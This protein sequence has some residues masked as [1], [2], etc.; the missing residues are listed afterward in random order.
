[1]FPIL[2]INSI[3]K[4]GK[5][6]GSRD[7]CIGD[8]GGPLIC[9]NSAKEPVLYG[10]TSWGIGCATDGYPG[11]YA[12]VSAIIDWI[13]EITGH[14]E[15]DVTTNAVTTTTPTTTTSPLGT[16]TYPSSLVDVIE[17]GKTK[18][19]DFVNIYYRRSCDFYISYINV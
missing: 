15:A 4:R 11:V 2:S 19:M 1:M 7:A 5:S 17:E 8:S 16:V 14:E 9:L 13:K 18:T 12:K 6:L 10:I 3:Y